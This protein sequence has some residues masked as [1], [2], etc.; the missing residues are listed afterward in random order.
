MRGSG[1]RVLVVRP[2][3]VHSR[4]TAG[5]P[6]RPFA[7]SAER[8]AADIVTG[9]ERRRAVVWTPPLLRW[10]FLVLNLLPE[11]LFRRLAR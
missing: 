10:A 2:G 8:A 1:A 3:F 11:P 4:M 5:R 7:I 9:I 6:R